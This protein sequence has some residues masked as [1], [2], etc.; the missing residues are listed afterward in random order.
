MIF[1]PFCVGNKATQSNWFTLSSAAPSSTPRALCPNWC[2]VQGSGFYHYT[3]V[4]QAGERL[5][6]IGERRR[7]D[8]SQSSFFDVFSF[9]NFFLPMPDGALPRLVSEPKD[10]STSLLL[11]Q[12]GRGCGSR[13]VTLPDVLKLQLGHVQQQSHSVNSSL[14]SLF[15]ELAGVSLGPSIAHSLIQEE[16]TDQKLHRSP[17]LK[18]SFTNIIY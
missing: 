8:H 2:R 15:L 12:V 4:K 17:C 16:P 7:E 3:A 11:I 6:V 13:V 14:F 18:Q 5:R 1:K 9:H 10:R